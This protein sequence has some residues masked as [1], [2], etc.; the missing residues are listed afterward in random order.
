M[1]VTLALHYSGSVTRTDLSQLFKKIKLCSHLS[2]TELGKHYSDEHCL[3]D[4][5]S[6]WAVNCVQAGVGLMNPVNMQSSIWTALTRSTHSHIQ[7]DAVYEI[8]FKWMSEVEALTADAA[9]LFMLWREFVSQNKIRQNK[10]KYVSDCV[11]KI[12]KF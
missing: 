8:R 4:E 6:V 1:Y 11:W 5:A 3:Q 10:I 9:L 12:S 7:V 2:S